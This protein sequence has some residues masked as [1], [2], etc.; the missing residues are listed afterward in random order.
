MSIMSPVFRVFS[1]L[2]VLLLS[3]VLLVQAAEKSTFFGKSD[4]P[5]DIVADKLDFDQ[6]NHLAVFSGNVVARQAETSLESDVL[7]VIFARGSEQDLKEIIATG[8]EVVIK[9]QGKKALCQKMH[10]FAAGR[11]IILTGSP[12]LDDGN[13]IISGE[14]IAFFID[15]ERSVVK[16]GQKSR[17]KTTIFPGKRGGLGAQ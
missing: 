8:K 17:V 4:D 15:E 1:V 13:N 10:Y 11:K 3:S 14:E 16:S 7:K 9:F 6:K 5:V 12:S 2:L